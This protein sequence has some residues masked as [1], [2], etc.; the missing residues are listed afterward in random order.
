MTRQEPRAWTTT[1]H[2]PSQFGPP[3]RRRSD[4]IRD[5]RPHPSQCSA[6]VSQ[7]PRRRQSPTS[8]RRAAAPALTSYA[9]MPC[10]LPAC[11]AFRPAV[12]RARS[13]TA[14][15]GSL[16][17]SSVSGHGGVPPWPSPTKLSR[18]FVPHRG[19]A[20]RSAP[21][22]GPSALRAPCYG[23][24][25]LASPLYPVRCVVVG[26][27]ATAGYGPCQVL[28]VFRSAPP[29]GGESCHTRPL[30]APASLL[31][32]VLF[33]KVCASCSAKAPLGAAHRCAPCRVYKTHNMQSALR[34]G[35]APQPPAL[36]G[37]IRALRAAA[38]SPCHGRGPLAS[39]RRYAQG[40]FSGLRPGATCWP[41]PAVP[42]APVGAPSTARRFLWHDA[43]AMPPTNA[44]VRNSN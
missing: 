43:E 4:S 42:S 5:A 12:P 30:R 38:W 29:E 32:I 33:C 26:S 19:H 27:V 31:H 28:G 18:S 13:I 10:A 11:V 41:P 21:A 36:P 7:P 17:C 37:R 3:G 23:A 16:C 15:P 14:L 39:V 9:V 40:F 8:L 44:V 24:D 1:F 20:S 34:W 2:H 6:S 22:F 25:R 35:W